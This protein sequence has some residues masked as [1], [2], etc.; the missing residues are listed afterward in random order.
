[1]QFLQFN[2]TPVASSKVFTISGAEDHLSVF[3]I[4]EF[5]ACFFISAQQ[6]ADC[7]DV[8]FGKVNHIDVVADCTAV[9]SVIII[10]ESEYA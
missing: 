9:V 8:G 7:Y 3:R 4:I 6:T 5:A 10:A 2:F 1:M